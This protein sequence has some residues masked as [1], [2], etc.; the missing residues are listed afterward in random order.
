MRYYEEKHFVEDSN[1]ISNRW[2][3]R[4]RPAEY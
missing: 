2:D 1:S 4:A 3:C